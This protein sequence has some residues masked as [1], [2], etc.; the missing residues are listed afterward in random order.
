[1]GAGVPVITKPV[2]PDRWYVHARFDHAAHSTM[3]CKTCHS[4]VLNS[5]K[6]SDVNLPD[7]ASC[8]TCHSAKGRVVSTCATCHDYHNKAP[9]KDVATT[10]ALRQ[11]M[12]SSP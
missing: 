9:A 12:M 4:T 6:T 2:T 5:E 11:M 8:V 1:M 7:K 10:S 3:D